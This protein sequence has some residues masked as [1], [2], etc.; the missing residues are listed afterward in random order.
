MRM[1]SASFRGESW[2][3]L[4]PSLPQFC[5]SSTEDPHLVSLSATPS[6]TRSNVHRLLLYRAIPEKSGCT[7]TRWLRKLAA[8]LFI[9][10]Y[11]LHRVVRAFWSWYEDGGAFLRSI[12]VD[13]YSRSS[14]KRWVYLFGW[15][16][17]ESG[18]ICWIGKFIYT[19]RHTTNEWSWRCNMLL[20]HVDSWVLII[21]IHM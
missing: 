9:S 5:H 12:E 21:S 13:T 19:E 4:T 3:S 10:S 17:A 6:C 14:C 15:L 8:F 16:C 20:V 11:W 2:E 18:K 1:R 7:G